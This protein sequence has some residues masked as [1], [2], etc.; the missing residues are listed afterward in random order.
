MTVVTPRRTADTYERSLD[1]RV[2]ELEALIEEARQRA[3][4]RRRRTGA[5]A[6][7]LLLAAGAAVYAGGDGIRVGSARSA[8]GNATLAAAL[9]RGG[10]WSAPTGPPGFPARIVLDPSRPGA[11]YLD[12]FSSGRVFRSANGG[13]SWS[14]GRPI[15][16]RI[17]ALTVDPRDG[18]ILYAGTSDGVLKSTDA[19]RTWRRLGLAPP[20]A[21]RFLYRDEGWAYGVDLDPTDSRIV[22]ART[23][24]GRLYRSTNGGTTWRRLWSAP[25]GALD[26]AIHPA[27]PTTLYAAE[28]QHS[29]IMRSTDSGRTWRT[30]ARTNGSIWSLAV[31]P[32]RPGT[33]WAAGDAGV[34]VTRDGGTTW[35]EPG[36]PPAG[37]LY[38][39]VVDPRHADTLYLNGGGG[40][41]RS[42]DGGRSWQPFGA[43]HRLDELVID[44]RAPGTMYASDGDGVV[45][46]TDGGATWRRADAGI[47]AS[48]LN[49]VAPAPGRPATIYAGGLSFRLSRS[50]NRGRTWTVLRT[51]P[52][53]VAS[54]AVNPRDHRH[55]LVGARGIVASRDGGASW[56]NVLRQHP[57]DGV[58]TIVFDPSD[59][60]WAY[61]ATSESGLI[62]SSDGGRTWQYLQGGDPG[63]GQTDS[64]AVHPENAGTVYTAGDRGSFAI[65][66]NSGDSW[67]Y[68]S[69]PGAKSVESLGVAP[70][71]PDTLYAA[72]DAGLARSVDGGDRWRLLPVRGPDLLAVVVDPKRPETVYVGTD[73]G[74]VLR[75]T[76]G[77]VSWQPFGKRL[78]SRSISTLAFDATGT[79]LYAGTSDAGLTSIRV[80]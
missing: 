17:D 72:T 2:A 19:G 16:S 52:S 45:K 10:S 28:N 79:V 65:S 11:L 27:A 31:D 33:I 34:L 14:S 46:T 41:F 68:G 38:H 54:V 20:P 1:E 78:P 70:S 67:R 6:L 43:G 76:N 55:V 23:I 66:T 7:A 59:P 12:V 35:L 26:L 36:R 58:H 37:T 25:R 3:R 80:R 56:V 50:D 30:V 13:R 5:V 49:A 39:I 44:P 63:P 40:W 47:V 4:R 9:D 29:G 61:A 22:Y 24:P 18:S 57:G 15:A 60:R 42:T 51:N 74:G 53:N 69:I 71:D 64:L 75:S 48:S 62:R 73:G 32:A 21:E 77:G 8:D